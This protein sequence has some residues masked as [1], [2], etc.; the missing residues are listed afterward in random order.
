MTAR[1]KV[2]RCSS[3]RWWERSNNFRSQDRDWGLCHFWGGRSG[4][5]TQIGF[6]DYSFGH[7]PRG[8]D[9]CE[10]HNTSPEKKGSAH[11]E[12]VMPEIKCAGDLL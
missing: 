3:C 8:G 12:G 5:R 9:T 7:E 1:A 2:P 6:I 11:L 4:H 10:W